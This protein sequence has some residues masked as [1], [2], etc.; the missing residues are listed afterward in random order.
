VRY[1]CELMVRFHGDNTGSNPVGDANQ[2]N[3]LRFTRSHHNPVGA[4]SGPIESGQKGA[5]SAQIA[6]PIL[7][8]GFLSGVLWICRL[9][10]ERQRSIRLSSRN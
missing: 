9:Q 2:I 7:S 8:E 6:S 10:G 1:C 3:I 4:V 5:I